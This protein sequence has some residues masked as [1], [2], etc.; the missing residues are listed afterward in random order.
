MFPEQTLPGRVSGESSILESLAHDYGKV[1]VG[2]IES[3][4]AY[5]CSMLFRG[6]SLSLSIVILQKGSQGPVFHMEVVLHPG[7]FPVGCQQPRLKSN[8]ISFKYLI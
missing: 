7:A 1:L 6:L 8:Q 2:I 5:N 4:F 3:I